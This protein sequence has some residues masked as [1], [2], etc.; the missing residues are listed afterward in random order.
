[1][2]SLYSGLEVFQRKDSTFQSFHDFHDFLANFSRIFKKIPDIFYYFSNFYL[3]YSIYFNHFEPAP[4]IKCNKL[5]KEGLVVPVFLAFSKIFN[6]ITKFHKFSRAG[7][8]SAILAGFPEA[9]ASLR[10]SWC[11]IL[12]W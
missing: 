4:D 2:L 5:Q 12:S 8:P 1:M 3:L 7:N 6:K 11:T 10:E 9:G